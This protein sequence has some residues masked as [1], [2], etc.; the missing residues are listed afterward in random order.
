MNKSTLKE[1]Y[2]T[3]NKMYWVDCRNN[4]SSDLQK[5]HLRNLN[6]LGIKKHKFWQYLQEYSKY[7][8]CENLDFRLSNKTIKS[9]QCIY[10]YLY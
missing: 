1:I 6:K 9:G 5:L 2:S 3:I 8:Q 7:K 4:H 10:L